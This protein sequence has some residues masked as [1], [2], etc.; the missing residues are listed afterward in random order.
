MRKEGS[1]IIAVSNRLEPFVDD[2]CT[3]MFTNLPFE[4]YIICTCKEADRITNELTGWDEMYQLSDTELK[5]LI[6]Y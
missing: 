3:V 1:K 6:E 5:D 4:L 2:A